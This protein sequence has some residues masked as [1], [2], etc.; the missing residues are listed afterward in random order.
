M[1]WAAS[2]SN[3]LRLQFCVER[4]FGVEQPGNRAAG[5]RAIRDGGEF[6]SVNVGDFRRHVQVRFRDGETRI[7]LF[8]RDGRGRVD[9]R[10]RE[11]G[12][13]KFRR[14]RHRETARVR[15]RNEFFG[16]RADAI[17]ETRAERVLRFLE[18]AALGGN[19][20]FASFQVASPNCGCFAFHKLN[21]LSM[22]EREFVR[23]PE[24]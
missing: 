9:G 17:F 10:G 6:F 5:L 15:R 3:N 12:L 7:G 1:K 24:S 21:F 2:R 4:N 18:R 16:V 13:A 11:T 23:A 8:H 19:V 20:A 22:T 14:E